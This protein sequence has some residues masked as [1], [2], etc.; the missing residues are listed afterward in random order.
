MSPDH[1]SSRGQVKADDFSTN[2]EQTLPV[3]T[4]LREHLNEQLRIDFP[5]LSE[6]LIGAYLIDLIDETGWMTENLDAIA[7]TLGCDTTII[8]S[9]LAR[10]QQFDPPGIFARNLSECLELQLKDL[11]RFDPCMKALLQNLDLLADNIS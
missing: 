9:I 7:D 10:L 8:E 6:R 3:N 2:I 11:N 1:N 4:S 5:D